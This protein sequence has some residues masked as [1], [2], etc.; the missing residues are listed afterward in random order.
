MRIKTKLSLNNQNNSTTH[1]GI[2]GNRW[3]QPWRLYYFHN[4]KSIAGNKPWWQ[5]HMYLCMPR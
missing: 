1:A 4:L 3:L 5:E 2:I